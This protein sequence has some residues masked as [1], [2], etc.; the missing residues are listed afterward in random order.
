MS[1]TRKTT[2]EAVFPN[3]EIQDLTLRDYFAAMAMQGI[4][5]HPYYGNKPEGEV[6]ELAYAQADKMLWEREQ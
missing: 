2:H 3:A 4:V 5:A 1:D 6:A